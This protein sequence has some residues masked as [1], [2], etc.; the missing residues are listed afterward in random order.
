[1][2]FSES[3]LGEEQ[4]ESHVFALAWSP[5]GLA[6]HNRCALAVLTSNLLLSVWDSGADQ[7][8][9]SSWRRDCIVNVAIRDHLGITSSARNVTAATS[10]RKTRIRAFAWSPAF[11]KNGSD[12]L[13]TA[14]G[15][16]GFLAVLN[17]LTELFLLR[18]ERSSEFDVGHA[19][20]L[21]VL[22]LFTPKLSPLDDHGITIESFEWH[23]WERVRGDLG[24][25][26]VFSSRR[27]QYTIHTNWSTSKEAGIAGLS[28]TIQGFDS[29]SLDKSSI[30]W[31]MH[32]AQIA[33]SRNDYLSE[34]IDLL[35]ATFDDEDELNGQISVR[36]WGLSS[37]KQ[38]V[39]AHISL[40]PSTMLQYLMP[41]QEMSHVV[42][43][44]ESLAISSEDSQILTFDWESS[45]TSIKHEEVSFKVWGFL[46]EMFILDR[47]GKVAAP[48][49]SNVI[50][51]W[52][53]QP[54]FSKVH[55][56]IC[57]QL[58]Y[59]YLCLAIV[60]GWTMDAKALELLK[61]TAQ[62]SVKAEKGIK[63]TIVS[64]SADSN[65][66]D[67]WAWIDKLSALL[68][69]TEA[70]SCLEYCDVCDQRLVWKGMD[71]AECIE[72]HCFG[73]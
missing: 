58:I 23:Q 8:D 11:P 57:Q 41:S 10:S 16:I 67:R 30:P 56:G 50:D 14:S 66:V 55:E 4:S 18:V 52:V 44:H 12:G 29:A 48:A 62:G 2:K 5:P 51:T 39:A 13:E 42:F 45:S 63:D 25:N 70:S 73:K 3:S 35:K 7:A 59:I 27:S 24:A 20:T 60:S 26:I 68:H 28:I 46:V 33:E 6:K 49:S 36:Y 65:G 9:A 69:E 47:V 71:Y 32:K 15:R 31:Y 34:R 72:G 64:I 53:E 61:W 1:M 17:D 21:S 37:Y 38:F 54:E 43:S 19:L 22:S 40:H